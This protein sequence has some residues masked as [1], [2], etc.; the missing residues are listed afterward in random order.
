MIPDNIIRAV[1]VK[2]CSILLDVDERILVGEVNKKRLAYLEK[3]PVPKIEPELS[4]VNNNLSQPV[5]LNTK[6]VVKKSA[7]DKFELAIIYY[8]VRFGKEPLVEEG[9]EVSDPM[10]VIDYVKYDLERDGMWF[11]HPLYTQM[12]EDAIAHAHE[13]TFVPSRFFLAHPDQQI[14]KIAAELLGD[15][16]QLS[17]V[18]TKQFGEDVKQEDTPMAEEKHLIKNVPR[19]LTELKDAHITKR[20]KDIKEEMEQKQKAGEWDA[21]I[22]LMRQIKDFEEIKKALSKALGE[23]IILRW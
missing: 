4:A 8:I 21:A 18:H 12:L 16:Y 14:S 6:P 20:I 11:A 7:I 10:T 2:D 15:R 13:E 1:Y 3:Q 9:Q 5:A 19:V 22:D 23:R 17:K